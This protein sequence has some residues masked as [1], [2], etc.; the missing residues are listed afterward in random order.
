MGTECIFCR[1]AAGTAPA[2][3]VRDEPLAMAFVDLRQFHAGHVLVIPKI[4]VPDVRSMDPATGAALLEMVSDVARAVSDE[5]PGDGLSIW[6]SVGEA[7]GQE[8]PHLH[9]HVHPRFAGD[10]MFR[11]YPDAPRLPGRTTLD[12]YA[13]RLRQRGLAG[14]GSVESVQ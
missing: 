6:H 14:G 1:I 8:V 13:A 2:S 7:G 4:H 12:H 9:F 11:V 3:V 5:F 10:G